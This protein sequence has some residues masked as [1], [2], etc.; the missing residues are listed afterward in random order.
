MRLT[1]PQRTPPNVGG[2]SQH[3]PSVKP[4]F[5]RQNLIVAATSATAKI[6][7]DLTIEPEASCSFII[8][9]FLHREVRSVIL[10]YLGLCQ[11]KPLFALPCCSSASSRQP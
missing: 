7:S 3:Q 1:S 10:Q 4:S 2:S 11:L 9:P 8:A 5:S 6:A